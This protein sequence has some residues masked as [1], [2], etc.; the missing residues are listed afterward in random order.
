MIKIIF[1]VFLN[2]ECKMNLKKMLWFSKMEICK[3]YI[4][5][6][7]YYYKTIKTMI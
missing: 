2:K 6:T 7:L 4:I 3:I 1:K 5:N